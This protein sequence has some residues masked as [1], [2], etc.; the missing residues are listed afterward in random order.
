MNV[1]DY[2]MI[3][4]VECDTEELIQVSYI[5]VQNIPTVLAILNMEASETVIKLNE[6]YYTVVSKY[7]APASSKAMYNTLVVEVEEL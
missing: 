1:N 6:T 3:R 2:Y 4:Y 7:F 5:P